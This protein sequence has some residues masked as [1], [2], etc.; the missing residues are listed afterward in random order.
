M[1]DRERLIEALKDASGP[2]HTTPVHV[3]L[4][5][6]LRIVNEVFPEPT[7]ETAK[8][9]WPQPGDEVWWDGTDGN[10]QKLQ[11]ACIVKIAG[12]SESGA[13][14]V[15]NT[16]KERSRKYW[17][18]FNAQVA[19]LTREIA[20]WKKM[21]EQQQKV[22]DSADCRGWCCNDATCNAHHRKRAIA[23]LDKEG[24]D[25]PLDR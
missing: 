25:E 21:W 18:V 2:G 5:S 7:P 9:S 1:T 17:N 3:T 10:G 13:F 20:I 4:A 12:F 23:A 15:P 24:D 22:C 8:P 16:S 19:D 14:M 6:A 11:H